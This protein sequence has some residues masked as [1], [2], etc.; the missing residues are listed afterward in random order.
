M[1]EDFVI[2]HKT[3][4]KKIIE[5]LKI[6]GP[7]LAMEHQQRECSPPISRHN[8]KDLPYIL[9]RDEKYGLETPGSQIPI[10][11]EK[12]GKDNNPVG[13]I[14]FPYILKRK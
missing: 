1:F 13:L 12:E 11:S 6:E 5:D 14:V 7:Y 4:L 8:K 3:D 9:E 10:I 2:N